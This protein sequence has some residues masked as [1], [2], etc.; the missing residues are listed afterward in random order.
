MND[1]SDLQFEVRDGIEIGGCRDLGTTASCERTRDKGLKLWK[2]GGTQ[3]S[4]VEWWMVRWCEDL[5]KKPDPG[6]RTASSYG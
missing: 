6:R 3:D 4:E 5:T 2:G 1:K